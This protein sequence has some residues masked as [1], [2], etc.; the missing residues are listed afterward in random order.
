MS[1][2]AAKKRATIQLFLG[3]SGVF[4]CDP[5]PFDKQQTE[6]NRF[7]KTNSLSLKLGSFARNL[8]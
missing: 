2:F 7:G 6:F 4:N 3:N 8:S 5:D 1:W